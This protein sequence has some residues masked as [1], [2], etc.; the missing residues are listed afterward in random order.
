MGSGEMDGMG[1]EGQTERP[2]MS[3]GLPDVWGI[4]GSSSPEHM[5]TLVPL[6]EALRGLSSPWLPNISGDQHGSVTLNR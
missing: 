1:K 3:T 6:V 4:G 2:S 5:G